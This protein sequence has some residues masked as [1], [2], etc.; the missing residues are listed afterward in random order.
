MKKVKTLIPLTYDFMFKR[1]FTQNPNLLKELLISIL[2]LELNPDTSE[3]IIENTELPKS[4]KKEYRKTVD[5]L[6]T[7]N[8]TKIIDVELNSSSFNE[9]KYR[10]TLYIEK[11]AT[12]K[13]ESGINYQDM[14]NYYFYQLNLN[15]HKFKDNTGEKMFTMK[16]DK[17]NE[18]LLDNLKIIYKS[19]DYYTKLY[20]TNNRNVSKDVI[21]LALINTKTFDELEEMSK[22]VMREKDRNKFLKDVK[23]ASQ[24]KLILSEWEADK[25]AELVKEETIKYAKLEGIEKGIEQGIEQGIEK[26]IEQGTKDMIRNLLKANIPIED[27]AR[28]TGKSIKELKEISQTNN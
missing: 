13:I 2:Q 20:Y 4:T 18:Q 14:S 25:M 26:G 27:I 21:W 6:V 16:D 17:T 1:V 19:L 3:I 15:I 8:N 7:I 22:L 9:I 10:N 24:D 5:I 23:N 11:V 12:N 28:A